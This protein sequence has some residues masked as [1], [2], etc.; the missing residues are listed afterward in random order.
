MYLFLSN[1]N[2]TNSQVSD[3]TAG[4]AF[5]S[6][7]IGGTSSGSFLILLFTVVLLFL[8]IAAILKLIKS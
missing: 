7:L 8:S 5:I 2:V 3:M 1:P 6:N 4:M